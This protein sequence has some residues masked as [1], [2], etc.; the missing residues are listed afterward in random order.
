MRITVVLILAV[1]LTACG[2]VSGNQSMGKKDTP[3]PQIAKRDVST[4]LTVEEALERQDGS[5]AEVAGY[6]TGQ[7]VSGSDV[8][9]GDFT[10]DYALALADEPGEADP[11]KML[12]VQIPSSQRPEA[13]LKTNPDIFGK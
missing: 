2:Q 9:T 11:E 13:G 8:L 3:H 10:N 6:V 7:P 5:L 1:F 12:F 4:P